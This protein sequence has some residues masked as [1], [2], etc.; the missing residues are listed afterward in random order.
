MTERAEHR[1]LLEVEALCREGV[2]S[3][4]AL[5]RALTKRG[6]TA[7]GGGGAWI[8]TTVGRLLDRTGGS[9]S[10]GG[11]GQ[12]LIYSFAEVAETA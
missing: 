4:Q 12:R 11:H 1:L 7:P 8:H 3:M 9:L 10:S 5:A 2:T 6:V